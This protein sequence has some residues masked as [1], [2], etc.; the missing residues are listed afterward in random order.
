MTLTAGAALY[1]VSH[2]YEHKDQK[3]EQRAMMA[4]IILLLLV[5]VLTIILYQLYIRWYFAMEDSPVFHF[6]YSAPVSRIK[7]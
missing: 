2:G 1:P 3:K 6:S 7:L 4:G 5:Q